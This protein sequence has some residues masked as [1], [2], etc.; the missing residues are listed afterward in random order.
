MTAQRETFPQLLARAA[1]ANAA[2][3]LL[4][5]RDPETHAVTMRAI[6]ASDG[7]NAAREYYLNGVLV[8]PVHK[9]AEAA[10]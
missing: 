9:T 5:K 2:I 8:L 10:P 7:P 3:M 6:V 1:D 4:V